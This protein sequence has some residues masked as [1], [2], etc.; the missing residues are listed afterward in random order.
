MRLHIVP[1]TESGTLYKIKFLTNRYNQP[2]WT[3]LLDW[4]GPAHLM[5][6]ARLF[7]FACLAFCGNRIF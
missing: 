3:A 4:L 2:R 5:P 1:G 6:L 7:A